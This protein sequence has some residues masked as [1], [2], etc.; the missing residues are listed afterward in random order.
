MKLYATLCNHK[1]AMSRNVD[2]KMGGYLSFILINR[3]A[4]L[5]IYLYYMRR[6][7]VLHPK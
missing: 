1:R 3:Y 2:I 6:L 7:F 5:G 4:T